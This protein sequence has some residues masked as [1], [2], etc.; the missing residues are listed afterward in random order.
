MELKLNILHVIDVMHIGT[1]D[2][3]TPNA[4]NGQ[5]YDLQGRRLHGTPSRGIYVKD[6]KK[7]KL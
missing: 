3:V 5:Y 4:V 7:V 2:T 1:P 6:G